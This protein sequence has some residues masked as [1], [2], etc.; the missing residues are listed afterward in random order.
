MPAKTPFMEY[1]LE[2]I[3]GFMR[4]VFDGME[5]GLNE[6]MWEFLLPFPVSAAAMLGEIGRVES[7]E[8]DGWG[9]ESPEARITCTPETLTLEDKLERDG[10]PLRIE[11]PFKDAVLLLRRWLFECVWREQQRREHIAGGHARR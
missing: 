4:P 2:V 7:G 8:L 6:L 3:D 11:L 5:P 1:R 9:F 10:A